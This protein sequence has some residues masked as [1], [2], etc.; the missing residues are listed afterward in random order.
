MEINVYSQYFEAQGVFS[1]VERRG[2]LVLLVSDSEAGNISYRAAVSFF[3]HRDEEDFAVSYDACFEKELYR[4]A[5][6]RSRKREAALLE[7]LPAE[8]DALATE[9][10]ATVLW[11]RPLSDV[12]RD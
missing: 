8:I 9:H 6:R 12:R 11:D 3:P 10:G 1:G 4:A 7:T 5:G 2:A